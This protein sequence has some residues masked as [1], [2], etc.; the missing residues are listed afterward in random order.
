[1]SHENE[2]T[3]VP[4]SQGQDVTRGI[5]GA[6]RYVAIRRIGTWQRGR[7]LYGVR[8][9]LSRSD[10]YESINV[11]YPDLAVTDFSGGS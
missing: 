7:E 3:P 8:T 2:T 4:T 10:A 9:F 11:G 5:V 6:N 1:M